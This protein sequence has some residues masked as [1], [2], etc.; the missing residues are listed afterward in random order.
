MVNQQVGLLNY[1][2]QGFRHP[3]PENCPREMYEIML[4]CWKKNPQERP[5]FEFLFNTMDDYSVAVES[6]DAEI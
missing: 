1:L 6:S 4:M 2:E 5:T 3:H